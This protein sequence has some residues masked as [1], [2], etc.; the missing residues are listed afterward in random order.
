MPLTWEQT[1]SA[2]LMEVPL[3]SCSHIEF[4]VVPLRLLSKA[5]TE[6]CA[7]LQTE[8]KKADEL[9]ANLNTLDNLG[10][11]PCLSLKVIGTCAY[12]QTTKRLELCEPLWEDILTDRDLPLSTLKEEVLFELKYGRPFSPYDLPKDLPVSTRMKLFEGRPPTLVVAKP[13]CLHLQLIKER[14]GFWK[15]VFLHPDTHAKLCKRRWSQFEDVDEARE[16]RGMRVRPQDIEEVMENWKGSNRDVE[17]YTTKTITSR[18]E[19]LLS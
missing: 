11:I 19:N 6:S 9:L 1:D 17:T 14:R 2:I 10:R 7:F 16:E 4:D 15:R 18:W 12:T 3:H 5:E 8:V 13:T